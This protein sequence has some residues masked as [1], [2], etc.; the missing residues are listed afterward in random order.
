MRN[1]ASHNNDMSFVSDELKLLDQVVGKYHR[2][3]ALDGWLIPQ[4]RSFER[5]SYITHKGSYTPSFVYKKFPEQRGKEILHDINAILALIRDKIMIS[6]DVAVRLLGGLYVEKLM[7]LRAQLL[8]LMGTEVDQQLL[9]LFPVCW[10]EVY[11]ACEALLGA[12]YDTHRDHNDDGTDSVS[13]SE[14]KL[15][16]E[17]ALEQ[18]WVTDVPVVIICEGNGW[19]R[20]AVRY[21]PEPRLE[22]YAKHTI[23]R[24]RAEAAIAHEVT[25]LR[26]YLAWSIYGL[27][28]LQRWTAAVLPEEEGGALAAAVQVWQQTWKSHLWL[29]PSQLLLCASYYAQFHGWREVCDYLRALTHESLPYAQI[30][31]IVARA[32]RGCHNIEA[33]GAYPK[34]RLYWI[35]YQQFLQERWDD[36]LW[37]SFF[38]YGRVKK[39]DIAVLEQVL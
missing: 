37:A 7:E 39:R 5:K 11:G 9:V 35:G 12:Y 38:S 30:F 21:L 1:D 4:N 28:L 29:L 36:W 3:L 22:L 31:S 14:W 34:W 33:A 17:R 10:A 2:V 16:A 25:H 32:K 20:C 13:V 19:A 18:W 26:R 24:T 27:Q 23:S 6:D 8:F 15:M